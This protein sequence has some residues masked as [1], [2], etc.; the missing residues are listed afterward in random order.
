MQS[1]SF[2][3][4]VLLI[5]MILPHRCRFRLFWSKPNGKPLRF[6]FSNGI[7]KVGLVETEF[8]FSYY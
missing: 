2:M 3:M 8:W 7:G 5:L 1:D 4:L 6:C